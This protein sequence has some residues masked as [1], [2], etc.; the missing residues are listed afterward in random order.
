MT[1]EREF[2]EYLRSLPR[3]IP[4]TEVEHIEREHDAERGPYVPH[5]GGMHHFA[6]ESRH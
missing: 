6:D 1:T 5:G 4:P 2:A 3:E